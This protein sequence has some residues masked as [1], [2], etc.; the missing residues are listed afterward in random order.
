MRSLFIQSPLFVDLKC[1]LYLIWEAFCYDFTQNIFYLALKLFCKLT[2]PRFVIS[3]SDNMSNVI[4][5]YFIMFFCYLNAVILLL[6]LQVLIFCAQPDLFYCWSF[7]LT[8]W[9]FHFQIFSLVF[10]HISIA[11]LNSIFISCSDFH[12]YFL[13]CHTE[14]FFVSCLILWGVCVCVCVLAHVSCTLFDFLWMICLRFHLTFSLEAITVWLVSFGGAG[15][16]GVFTLPVLFSLR[17]APVGL[18]H[19]INWF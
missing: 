18:C 6:G 16:P 15:L 4:R 13:C 14:I 10:F 2:T 7:P 19:R 11:L 1:L 8:C 9:I 12:C 5:S 17:C 3:I